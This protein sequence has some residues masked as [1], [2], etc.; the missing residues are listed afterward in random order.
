M[1]FSGSNIS[2][3]E[4]TSDGPLLSVLDWNGGVQIFDCSVIERLA[5]QSLTPIEYK[6]YRGEYNDSEQKPTEMNFNLV[7]CLVLRN[8]VGTAL[9]KLVSIPAVTNLQWLESINQDIPSLAFFL[10]YS[11]ILTVVSFDSSDQNKPEGHSQEPLKL[12][13]TSVPF[14]VAGT[15]MESHKKNSISFVSLRKGRMKSSAETTTHLLKYV[16]MEQLQPVAIVETLAR[17]SKYEEAINSAKNLSKQEQNKLDSVVND[18][19]RKLWENKRN[20]DSL[21]ATNDETYILVEVLSIFESDENECQ[22][23][24]DD[25]RSLLK[26]ALQI[27]SNND[28]K[29][30]RLRKVFVRLGTFELLCKFYESKA[31]FEQ[32]QRD[33]LEV[34][35]HDLSV[36]LARRGDISALSIVLFRHRFEVHENLLSIL[37]SIPLSI[38]SSS[39][40]HLLPVL[41]NGHI[42]DRFL[43]FTA[44]N[45]VEL[46]WSHM[47]QYTLE[48]YTISIVFDRFDELIVLEYNNRL[49]DGVDKTED[50]VKSLLSWFVERAKLMQ[51]F[52]GDV[53]DVINFTK[54]GMKCFSLRNDENNYDTGVIYDKDLHVIWR[55]ALSLKRM[56][57]DQS[58]DDDGINTD[59]L[60]SMNL[61]E[62]LNLVLDCDA[63]GSVIRYRFHEY[64][65]PLVMELSS[66]SSNDDL[67]EAL[68]AYCLKN[69]QECTASK[70]AMAK[71]VLSSSVAIASISNASLHKKHRLI[72]SQE[73]LI[74]MV[75]E[76]VDEISKELDVVEVSMNDRR[77][78]VES[79]WS[80][81]ETLPA[82][83]ASPQSENEEKLKTLYDDLVGIDIVSRW[84]GCNPFQFH[85]K[86]KRMFQEENGTVLEICKSF[87]SV[88]MTIASPQNQVALLQDL[89]CDVKNL[90]EVVFKNSIDLPTILCNCL[91]PKFLEE[92]CFGLVA[93]YLGSNKDVMD[94]NQVIHIVTEYVDEAMFSE[95]DNRDRIVNAIKCQ[96][97]LG[98]LL[99]QIQPLFQS[100]RRFLDASHFI[101]S[102]LLDGNSLAPLSPS[103]L[104]MMTALDAVEMILREFPQCIGCRCSQW[105][106][107]DYAKD[108]NKG[109]RQ[110]GTPTS[111]ETTTQEN[112]ELPEL[113]GGAIFHLATILGL[114]SNIAALVVKSRV[115][116]H[117]LQGGY[118]GAG[119]AIAR[120]LLHDQEFGSGVNPATDTIILRTIADLVSI[121]KYS[122]KWTK[123]ELCETV[124]RRFDKEVC[125]DNYQSFNVILQISSNLDHLISRFDQ[126]VGI[127]S[128]DR[129]QRLLSRP[130]ARLYDH[131]LFEY[132]RDMHCLFKD[133]GDQSSEGLV[134]DSL[135]DVLSRFVFYWCI[136][137]S[138][139]T[140]SVID[141]RQKADSY[142]NLKLGCGLVLQIPSIHTAESS[143]HEL[144]ET[145]LNQAGRVASE[146]RFGITNDYIIPNPDILKHLIDRGF[147]EN[148]ARKAAVMT[149]NAGNNEAM[150]WAVGHA[151]DPDLNNPLIL[152]KSQRSQFIDEG[153]I[154]MLQKSLIQLSDIVSNPSFRSAFLRNLTNGFQSIDIPVSSSSKTTTNS[155]AMRL[156]KARKMPSKPRSQI[157]QKS[158][159]E[160]K[161]KQPGNDV[162]EKIGTKMADSSTPVT[163]GRRVSSNLITPNTNNRV[164]RKIIDDSKTQ[165]TAKNDGNKQTKQKERRP[166][167]TPPR[168]LPH[169]MS[170]STEIG[171]E[172]STSNVKSDTKVGNS[173]GG[174]GSR[175][176]ARTGITDTAKLLVNKEAL[177][178]RGQMAL[179][180][181]KNVGMRTST[182]RTTPGATT[183]GVGREIRTRAKT[184][185]LARGRKDPATRPEIDR[186]ELRKRGQAA[187]DRLRSTNNRPESRSRLIEE[188]RRLLKQSKSKT[189]QPPL[190]DRT[191]DTTRSLVSASSKKAPSQQSENTRAETSKP[192]VSSVNNISRS[193][194]PSAGTNKI[195]NGIGKALKIES[196]DIDEDAGWDFDDFD[197]F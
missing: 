59:D 196:D 95:G 189:P 190:S 84:P 68:V 76:M 7:G 160:N 197:N 94:E 13:I 63:E 103:D 6:Q 147:T 90:N 120:T 177:T 188:G 35:I 173:P 108:A 8:Q 81:Y 26:L 10:N 150:A 51:T 170:N 146:E 18:C 70:A 80:L 58:I 99:P 171:F 47:P 123:K 53:D 159:V 155:T 50:C 49:N 28:E 158:I 195:E 55:T 62:L 141:L 5:S 91:I 145:S 184:G 65:Q 127:L 126:E 23:S 61:V 30:E 24:L 48:K 131:T 66:L 97:A 156:N 19:H 21:I 93:S 113:P 115:I 138:I 39:Y 46:P 92:G 124:L 186:E 69:V 149:S 17:E 74:L 110:A 40:W 132:K 37:G 57:L 165:P 183:T 134:H 178:Q 83:L 25:L 9:K 42:V 29:G 175:I 168:A 75:L 36:E 139:S 14:P 164:I 78:I 161:L 144:Q 133:L 157:P 54:V 1:K 101:S 166:P 169:K 163:K 121:E 129:K 130:I 148:A 114:E 181:L 167:P 194:T 153:A 111:V 116:Y 182:E 38:Q 72:K 52:V 88:I 185:I 56:L 125:I 22:F 16:I 107:P 143:V 105:M 77:E 98:P 122:D 106:D 71:R 112:T 191:V 140:R 82:Q 89:L 117:A 27:I 11:K 87:T 179:E 67:D 44:E 41:Q 128:P 100:N 119:A 15:A 45:I 104:K 162:A 142:E 137:D 152:L 151:M 64:I 96:D 102:V 34:D 135:M 118:Y 109:L 3:S 180:K 20:V 60:A 85:N 192:I 86:R 174:N 193:N 4:T 154:Q 32:F 176:K 172:D 136:H 12:S 79:F 33:F 43:D 73:K 2:T 187:L 31:S